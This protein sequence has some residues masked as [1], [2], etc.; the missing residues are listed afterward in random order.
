M[1]MLA[2]S[3]CGFVCGAEGWAHEDGIGVK[4]QEMVTQKSGGKRIAHFCM[5]LGEKNILP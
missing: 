5:L 3:G 4:T 2:V 1:V